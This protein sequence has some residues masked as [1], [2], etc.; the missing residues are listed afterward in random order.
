MIRRFGQTARVYQS[1]MSTNSFDSRSLRAIRRRKKAAILPSIVT[2]RLLP[3]FRPSFMND[4]RGVSHAS[5]TI[6]GLPERSG[7]QV[8]GNCI[9]QK[10]DHKPTLAVNA[11]RKFAVF[12]RRIRKAL[13]ERKLLQELRLY[14]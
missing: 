1:A 12:Q 3:L 2:R 4:A 13:V 14:R 5:H 9:R 10:L 8:V 7:M 11:V 6:A